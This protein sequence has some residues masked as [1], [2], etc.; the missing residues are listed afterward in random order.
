M[1]DIFLLRNSIVIIITMQNEV[2]EEDA[3]DLQ[4]AKGKLYAVSFYCRTNPLLIV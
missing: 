2:V 4:F 1:F 3:A